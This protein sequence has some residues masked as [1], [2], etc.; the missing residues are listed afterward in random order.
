VLRDSDVG[1]TDPIPAVSWS[2][3]HDPDV[4]HIEHNHPTLEP[5]ITPGNERLITLALQ[6][7]VL[8]PPTEITEATIH[9]LFRTARVGREG[10]PSTPAGAGA[11][12]KGEFALALAGR[13]AQDRDEGHLT[14]VV[15]A[16][17]VR[18]FQFLYPSD[19]LDTAM[20]ES[21]GA[22]DSGSPDDGN[23][24]AATNNPDGSR[25]EPPD[26]SAD[27]PTPS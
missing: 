11:S 13:L 8:D 14:A 16:H 15:P 5:A 9:A 22:S 1:M 19:T 3:A 24:D 4:L 27:P 10:A 12:R 18:L 17:L 6:D 23:T 26:T 20:V 21:A 25:T 2:G 7:I